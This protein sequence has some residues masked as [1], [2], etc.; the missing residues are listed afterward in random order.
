MREPKGVEQRG[1][2]RSVRYFPHAHGSACSAVHDVG[3]S[4]RC[5]EFLRYK[6][7]YRRAKISLPAFFIDSL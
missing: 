6:T 5:K 2:V 7:P 4:P 3:P 1:A